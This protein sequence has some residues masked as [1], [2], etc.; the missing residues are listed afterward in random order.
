VPRFLYYC[1]DFF[2]K[3]QL[4]TLL[5]H[6]SINYKIKL[7][8]GNTLGF[9]HLNKHSLEELTAIQDYLTD[10]LAKGF[11]VSSKAPFS[12]PV[13][14]ARKVNSGLCFCVDY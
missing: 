6:Y 14:F 10:N 4:D 5:P 12:S 7:I 9:S 2:L 11:V 13:L 3:K 8:D 1:L